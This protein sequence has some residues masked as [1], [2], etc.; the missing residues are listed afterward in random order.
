MQR[1]KGDLLHPAVELTFAMLGIVRCDATGQLFRH[2]PQELRHGAVVVSHHLPH[3][4]TG[5]ELL[6]SLGE[7]EDFLLRLGEVP[8]GLRMD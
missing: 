4:V 1:G 5:D 7:V 6:L 3:P 2:G 8:G